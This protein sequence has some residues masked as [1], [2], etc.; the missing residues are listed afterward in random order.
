MP[1]WSDMDCELEVVLREKDGEALMLDLAACRCEG[2]LGQAGEVDLF[3]Q[4][5]IARSQDKAVDVDG[6]PNFARELQEGAS[7]LWLP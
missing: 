4:K 5:R 1:L 6:I 7:W 2:R 3:F